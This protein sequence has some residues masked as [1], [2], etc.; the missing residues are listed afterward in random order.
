[1]ITGFFDNATGKYRSDYNSPDFMS[2][3]YKS[4]SPQGQAQAAQAAS[5]PPPQVSQ[6]AVSQAQSDLAGMPG[7][8]QINQAA[9]SAADPFAAQRGQY[10]NSLKDLMSGNFSSSDPSY[11]ARFQG[12]QQALE[13]SQAAKGFLG[14][15]NMLTAL[16]DYGQGQASQEYNNQYQRL[17][18]LTGATTGSPA[19]AGA[20]Q[21]QLYDWRNQALASQ[22]AGMTNLAST[23][24]AAQPNASQNVLANIMNQQYTT[25][26]AQKSSGWFY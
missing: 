5:A 14:S 18:P 2:A 6:M 16:Q 24:P 12:G 13:R 23:Q 15:G 7:M 20:L 21:G 10:Q 3:Y 25:Q 26:P 19:A 1:M 8:Q 22:G 4:Q 17:M 11:Q 9:V